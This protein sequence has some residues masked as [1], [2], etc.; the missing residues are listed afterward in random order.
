MFLLRAGAEPLEGDVQ[1]HPLEAY[2]LQECSRQSRTTPGRGDRIHEQKKRGKLNCKY[3]LKDR[4]CE[5]NII[6]SLFISNKSADPAKKDG[7]DPDS[8]PP[9]KNQEDV[10]NANYGKSHELEI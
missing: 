3:S 9:E 1:G 7:P 4:L 6:P 8:Y 2:R 5:Y 10:V